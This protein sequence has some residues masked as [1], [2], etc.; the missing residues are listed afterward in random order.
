M[1][2]FAATKARIN[3]RALAAIPAALDDELPALPPA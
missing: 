3:E 2:S 1:G